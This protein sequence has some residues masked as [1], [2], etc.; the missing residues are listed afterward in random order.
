MQ[1]S[2]RAMQTSHRETLALSPRS[3]SRTG[4]TP[5]SARRVQ[6]LIRRGAGRT[7]HPCPQNDRAGGSE[8]ARQL[9]PTTGPARNEGSRRHRRRRHHRRP[10][11]ADTPGGAASCCCAPFNASCHR[12]HRAPSIPIPTQTR[13]REGNLRARLPRSMIPADDGRDHAMSSLWLRLARQCGQYPL[14]AGGF[15]ALA[16]VACCGWRP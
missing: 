9:R 3:W 6:P 1:T 13:S 11:A 12:A 10:R 16:A 14:V 4:V 2:P 15:S 5:S 7:A 8:F